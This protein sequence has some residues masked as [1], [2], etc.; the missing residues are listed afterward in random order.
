ML[1]TITYHANAANNERGSGWTRR[2]EAI[3]G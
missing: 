3:N 2:R 1:S